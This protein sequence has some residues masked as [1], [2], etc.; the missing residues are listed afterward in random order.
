VNINEGAIRTEITTPDVHVDVQPADVT[1]EPAQVNI[2]APPPAN[3]T[4]EPTRIEEGAVQVTV[5]SPDVRP[6]QVSVDLEPVADGLRALAEAQSERERAL[7]DPAPPVVNIT[8]EVP[9]SAVTVNVPDQPA[10]VVN[11]N[12]EDEPLDASV[13]FK[14]RSDGTIDSAQITENPETD[15]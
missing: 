8:N 12:I 4:V 7:G 13:K 11:V 1:V 10:P 6:A 9:P 3:I 2:E 5:E 14:R 15:G